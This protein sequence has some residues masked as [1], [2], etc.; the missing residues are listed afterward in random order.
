[1]SQRWL[2]IADAHLTCI[3]PEDGFFRMLDAAARL[4]GDVGVIFLGDVFDLWIA[5]RGY[6]NAEHRR[7]LDWCRGEKMKRKIIFLEGNHEFFVAKTYADAFTYAG[8]DAYREG[9]LLWLHGDRINKEDRA[10]AF[11]RFIL[12]NRLTRRLLKLAGPTF[13]PSFAHYVRE[14]LRTTNQAHKRYFPEPQALR[15]LA[16]CPSGSVVFAGHFHDRVTK[17]A[18]GRIL[19]VLPAYAS[20]SEIAYYDPA[21]PELA[22]FPAD[23]IAGVCCKPM[24]QEAAE[25]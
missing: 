17:T 24:N 18:D 10:Y 15:F 22:V 23:R 21:G 6:E 20:A 7:F 19:E 2:M 11:L 16:S 14:R 25:S 12:R 4:P 8:E 3:E 9:D 13:G 1:M 5:L